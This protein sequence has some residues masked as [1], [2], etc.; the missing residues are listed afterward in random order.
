MSVSVSTKSNTLLFGR[1]KAKFFKESRNLSE[2]DHP[3]IVHVVE[4]FEENDTAYYVMDY[5]EGMSLSDIIKDNPLDTEIAI[6]YISQ[7]GKALSYIH[8]KRLNHLDIKPANIMIRLSDSEPI[9]ID[10]GLSKRYDTKG[11][12]TSTTPTGVSAGYAPIEQYGSSEL[13]NF[14][15]QTDIYSLAATLYTMLTG[16]RPPEA[17]TLASQPLECP[18]SI[19]HN[20]ARVILR[21]MSLRRN[22]RHES[23][24]EFIDELNKRDEVPPIPDNIDQD[25]P[26][27]IDLDDI[28][29]A[30]DNMPGGFWR[31]FTK[32][33]PYIENLDADTLLDIAKKHF[34]DKQIKKLTIIGANR[35]HIQISSPG[36]TMWC[37]T[38]LVIKNKKK[39][40]TQ[41]FV[42]KNWKNGATIFYVVLFGLIA[43][44]AF[45]FSALWLKKVVKY[46]R[47][48]AEVYDTELT[49]LA[50]QGTQEQY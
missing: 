37:C 19:P 28:T 44:P 10:F 4:A 11:N 35:F 31:A 3:N 40:K 8:D 45:F 5:I 20:I 18:T 30:K 49:H 43:I 39:N 6:K 16:K 24:S 1:L 36:A 46:Y 48:V 13:Q 23:V 26:I 42:R 50:E 9:L 27:E 15:A 41:L 22:D 33:Y 47:R 2:L 25:K 7:I 29:P 12:Q 34:P 14:S 38:V 21:G 17:T 32:K